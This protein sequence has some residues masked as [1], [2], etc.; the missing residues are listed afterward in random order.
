M[1]SVNNLRTRSTNERV[2]KVSC[3]FSSFLHK[4]KD[5]VFARFLIEGISPFTIELGPVKEKSIL[6][7][8]WASL[9]AISKVALVVLEH[10]CSYAHASIIQTQKAFGMV[11]KRRAFIVKGE[12]GSDKL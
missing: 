4:T 7:N 5:R 2:V 12:F 9:C 6:I 3:L 11:G 10:L 8:P 1:A